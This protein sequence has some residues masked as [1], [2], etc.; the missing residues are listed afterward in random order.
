MSKQIYLSNEL[1]LAVD[2]H[3]PA[4]VADAVFNLPVFLYGSRNMLLRE[5]VERKSSK[6]R[7]A[8]KKAPTHL[9]ADYDFIIQDSPDVQAELLKRRFK[10]V[11]V[12]KMYSLDEET[13]ALFLKTV[14]VFHEEMEIQVILKRDFYLSR[15]AWMSIDTDFYYR[16]LWKSSPDFIMKHL[17]SKD[18][19][20]YLTG[21]FNNFYH[22]T[23]KHLE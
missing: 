5:Q 17:D 14:R 21:Q 13:S 20:E 16:Y 6:I 23:R 12:S 8:M 7:D 15:K 1:S 2:K 19:K 3:V 4:A 18:R 10:K 11:D 22:M 9:Q